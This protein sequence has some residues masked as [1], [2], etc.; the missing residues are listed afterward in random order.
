[1]AVPFTFESVSGADLFLVFA[2]L[3]DFVLARFVVFAPEAFDD[4]FE[5]RFTAFAM[6]PPSAAFGQPDDQRFF[7][8]LVERR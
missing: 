4:F 1:L 7:L 5:P 3:F 2:A 6:L 8:L